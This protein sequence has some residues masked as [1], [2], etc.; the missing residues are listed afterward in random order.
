MFFFGKNVLFVNKLIDM[1]LDRKITWHNYSSDL[2]KLNDENMMLFFHE[3]RWIDPSNSFYT[4]ID[5]TI[6]LLIYEINDSGKG[7]KDGTLLNK[8]SLYIAEEGENGYVD[9]VSV[10]DKNYSVLAELSYHI[11]G[12]VNKENPKSERFIDKIINDP[13]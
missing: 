2:F 8:Y 13:D 5:D 4:K 1:T 10:E 12:I 11:K 7:G 3:Y 9:N 6:I